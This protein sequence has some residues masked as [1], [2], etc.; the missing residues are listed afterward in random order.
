MA[1]PGNG[2]AQR[3]E[4]LEEAITRAPLSAEGFGSGDV[5]G[6]LDAAVDACRALGH[7][8]RLIDEMSMAFADHLEKLLGEYHSR[9]RERLVE[10][11]RSI[12]KLGKRAPSAS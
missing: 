12:G 10:L 2:D 9:I 5:V 4:K 11:E 8:G 6:R 3:L 7:E 1:T